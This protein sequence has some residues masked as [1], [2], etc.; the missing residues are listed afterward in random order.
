MTETYKM[1]IDGEWVDSDSGETF[2]R[3]NPATLETIGIFQKGNEM[4][5]EAAVSAAEKAFNS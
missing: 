3:V 4:S 1:Y 2:S 5:V